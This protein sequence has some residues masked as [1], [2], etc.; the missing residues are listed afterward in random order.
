MY[1]YKIKQGK[2]QMY[3]T[4]ENA[5]AVLD[6]LR[7]AGVFQ[8]EIGAEIGVTQSAV[9]LWARGEVLPSIEYWNK[10][11]AIKK[12]IDDQLKRT[13]KEVLSD[14]FRYQ[15]TPSSV[16]VLSSYGQTDLFA[17]FPQESQSSSAIAV[18]E[19]EEQ[20]VA[21]KT[22]IALSERIKSLSE[23]EAKDLLEAILSATS[24]LLIGEQE[25]TKNNCEKENALRDLIEEILNQK[26][27]S[28]S[29]YEE[30]RM[31]LLSKIPID[32]AS[33]HYKEF[34]DFL[35]GKSNSLKYQYHLVPL[36]FGLSSIT[37]EKFTPEDLKNLLDE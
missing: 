36:A 18:L 20:A 26:G 2:C 9:S 34:K 13:A 11:L 30:A 6:Y 25:M 14:S 4:K 16:S 24:S 28:L 22:N 1:K 32:I 23:K 15:Y 37:G 27:L 10:I 8:R 35:Q 12:R 33:S 17:S 3:R 5:V 21:P 19:K 29:D 31:Y 7:M